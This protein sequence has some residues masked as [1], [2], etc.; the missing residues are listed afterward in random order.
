MIRFAMNSRNSK[1]VFLLC[2]D[3]IIALPPGLQHGDYGQSWQ[4]SLAPWQP[5]PPATHG[6]LF[7]HCT[8]CCS[9]IKLW[10]FHFQNSP[11]CLPGDWWMQLCLVIIGDGLNANLSKQHKFSFLNWI[12][13]SHWT[14]WLVLG[15]NCV[16]FLFDSL[17]FLFFFFLCFLTYW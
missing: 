2:F 17:R 16:V 9:R 15:N 12:N 7:W 1:D 14:L 8:W 6:S 5:C 13:R 11:R 4:K 3:L 10:I